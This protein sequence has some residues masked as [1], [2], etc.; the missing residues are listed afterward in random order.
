[1]KFQ[2]PSM[3]SSKL[4]VCIKKSVMLKMPKMTKG[5][6]LRSIFQ[7]LF[8]IYTVHLL[9]ATNLFLKF[10]GSSFNSF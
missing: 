5:H 4:M 3:L 10:Q 1:M 7:N 2:Y 6:N 8:K 9:N